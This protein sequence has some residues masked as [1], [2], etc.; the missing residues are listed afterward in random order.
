VRPDGDGL[1]LWYEAGQ[2]IF[3]HLEPRYNVV[4]PFPSKIARRRVAA[5]ERLARLATMERKL[6]LT[7]VEE[8]ML[9]GRQGPAK[10]LA[11]EG[12]VQLGRAY[13]A[14]RM[15]EI[16]YAHI[17]AGMALYLEDVE[18]IEGLADQNAM[19][20]VPA[21]VNIANAD[22]VN[23]K[24]TGAPEKL[25]KLQ[26]RAASAHH[27]M[28]SACSFTCTP[29]WAGHCA[30]KSWRMRTAMPCGSPTARRFCCRG[31]MPASRPRW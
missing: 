20:A 15:V 21:S 12:L 26:Q 3:R 8:D 2:R 14:P 28:G 31:S 23:W 10:K 19:M 13:G 9:A 27:R 29:Y 4:C 11:L 30:S 22:T 6:I 7:R 1:R 5:C 17:H 16:G 18:L 24:Q 25:V